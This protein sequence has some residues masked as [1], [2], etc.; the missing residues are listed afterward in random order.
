[1][2]QQNLTPDLSRSERALIPEVVLAR[3]K[4]D[5]TLVGSVRALLE[6]HSVL[7]TKAKPR[8]MRLLQKTFGAKIVRADEQAGVLIIGDDTFDKSPWKVAVVSAGSSDY[9]VAEEAS[10]CCEYFG[11]EVLRHYD[12]GIAGVHRVEAMLAAIRDVRAVIAVAGMEG[13]LP[14]V[15]AARI[16]QPLVAVPT[17][18]GYGTG[19]KGFAALL[20]MLNTCAPGVVVVNIDN[21]FGAAAFV[22]KIFK[23][24]R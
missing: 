16:K 2:R 24:M 9:F 20:T 13:A 15:I 19:R 4:D 7:V 18:V 6:K 1:V 21:G 10:L 11:F 5:E 8:Q 12:C 23:S 3:F 17:S 14:S 22:Y